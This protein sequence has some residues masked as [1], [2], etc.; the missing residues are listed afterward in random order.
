MLLNKVIKLNNIIYAI[1][2]DVAGSRSGS[3][4]YFPQ[5]LS[6][7]IVEAHKEALHPKRDTYTD[8]VHR[9]YSLFRKI[10]IWEEALLRFPMQTLP[11]YASLRRSERNAALTCRIRRYRTNNEKL[12]KYG[13]CICSAQDTRGSIIW[14]PPSRVATSTAPVP[15]CAA[16]AVILPAC[17]HLPEYMVTSIR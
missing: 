16:R 3:G 17:R 7:S 1:K 9:E 15:L 13:N 14:Q 12:K 2:K 11:I 4:L 8:P 10:S 5:D 6:R